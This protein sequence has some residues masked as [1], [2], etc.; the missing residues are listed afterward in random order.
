VLG[1]DYYQFLKNQKKRYLSDFKDCTI[2][3]NSY[4]NGAIVWK[5]LPEAELTIGNYCS[6]AHGV[7]LF[8]DSGFHNKGMITTYPLFSELYKKQERSYRINDQWTK[9]QYFRY[10]SGKMSI[11]IAN[12]VWIGTN[13][14]IMPGV[15]ISDGAVVLPGSV[16][17]SDVGPYEIF[18]GVPA[19]KIGQRFDEET[20]RDLLEI[21]WWNWEEALIR[22]RIVDF[23]GD[24]SEFVKKYR[25]HAYLFSNP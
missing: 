2:G 21:K 25:H 13:A 20:I 1:T 23:Y 14:M 6:L 4:H 15:S 9:A 11:H 16:V 19:K 8:L 3:K 10:V 12:D 18:G 22:Q 24:P 5:W 17:N 7:E